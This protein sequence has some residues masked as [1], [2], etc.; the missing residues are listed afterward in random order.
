VP[1]IPHIAV[2]R[3]QTKVDDTATKA[4]NGHSEEVKESDPQKS[5]E[6]KAPEPSV[7]QAPKSWADL[8]RA[9]TIKNEQNDAANKINAA[10]RAV[11]TNVNGKPQSLSE[12]IKSFDIGKPQDTPFLQPRGLINT[13]NMCFMNA[14]R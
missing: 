7:P 12:M 5:T 13:G 4:V 1:Y 3:T 6:D 11:N 10:L 9:K 8:V 2:P 14:V